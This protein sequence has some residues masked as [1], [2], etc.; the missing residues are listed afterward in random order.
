MPFG[1]TR[2]QLKEDNLVEVR[3]KAPQSKYNMFKEENIGV[4]GRYVWAVSYWKG[5]IIKTT[6]IVEG[7]GQPVRHP[8]YNNFILLVSCPT[9]LW[10]YRE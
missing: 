4:L 10:A 8:K 1:T 7:P 9:I 3:G 6:R 2:T 5:I